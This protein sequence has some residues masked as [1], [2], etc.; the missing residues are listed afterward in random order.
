MELS[1]RRRRALSTALAV[2][3]AV[4]SV[5]AVA[6]AASVSVRPS[7]P[8]LPSPAVAAAGDPGPT[9]ASGA[10]GARAEGP[11]L[12]ANAVPASIAD[13]THGRTLERLPDAGAASPPGPSAAPTVSMSMVA[14]VGRGALRLAAIHPRSKPKASGGAPAKPVAHV[15]RNHVWIPSLGV[16]RS[17]A[18]FPCSR[19][20]A[21][22]NYLY[23][24]GCA[25]ANNV[26][27]MGHAYGVMKG[28][29]DAWVAGRLRAGMTAWYADS[30]GV[31][32]TYR[33]KW[34]KVTAPTTS[35]N[36]AWAA[37]RVPSMTLQTCVGKNS[38]YRLMV[39]L[40]EV[41]G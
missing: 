23:R 1:P 3:L 22:D 24:W 6:A 10:A 7:G 29:H 39:R 38:A 40:V 20:R 9:R 16:N 15:G 5:S 8:G 32:H 33:V 31:V 2:V 30:R 21:P 27:L 35:A 11:V 14:R 19:S 26:Y 18:W 13:A 12:P 41:K 34:W 36:W 17:V 28:L 37:Q 25:G 4:E